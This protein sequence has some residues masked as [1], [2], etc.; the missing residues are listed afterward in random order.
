MLALLDSCVESA[1]HPTLVACRDS[2]RTVC[3]QRTSTATENNHLK[4]RL[5]R[6]ERGWG[7]IALYLG[8]MRG[9]GGPNT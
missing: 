1:V 5:M 7:H 9:E 6:R 2:P 3:F 8:G 4:D